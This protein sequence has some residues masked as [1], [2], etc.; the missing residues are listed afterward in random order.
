MTVIFLTTK[1]CAEV[2]IGLLLTYNEADVIEE[3]MAHNRRSVDTVFVLDGSSDGTDHILTQYPEVELILK[4]EQVAPGGRVRDFHRQAL[5]EVAQTRYGYGHWFTLMHG[6]ELFHDDP[7]IVIERAEKQGASFVNWAALQFFMHTSD[8]PLDL[9]LPLQQRLRWYSPFWVEVRQFKG[10]RNT[11]YRPGE[12]GRVLPRHVG[13]RP[14]S[15]MPLLKHYPY[16]SPEQM[17]KRLESQQTRGFSGTAPRPEIYRDRYAPEYRSAR[18][19]DGDFG[20]LELD[21][22]GNLLTMLW[23]WKRLVR[24]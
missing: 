24:P 1:L 2:N 3:M 15:K 4:D 19:F 16:R 10:G 6:D 9:G 12:H 20:D 21:K 5:L 7:R 23:R 17:T 22:Q 14:Y 13:W 11:C 18:H 8:E